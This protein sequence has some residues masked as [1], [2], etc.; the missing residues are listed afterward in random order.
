MQKVI[1][2]T[3]NKPTAIDLKL[4]LSQ[5]CKCV[6]KCRNANNN[7]AM[8]VFYERKFDAS[9][10][11]EMTIRLPQ[12]AKNVLIEVDVM[13]GAEIVSL[14]TKKVRLNSYAPCYAKDIKFIRFAQ[15]LC[16]MLPYLTASN[17]PFTIN[18][19]SIIVFQDIPNTMTPARIHNETGVIEVSKNKMMFNTVPVNM[20]ILL[21]E[22]SHF[23][24]NQDLNDEVEADLNSVKMYLGLGYPVY[25]ILKG[26]SMVFDHADVPMNRERYEYLQTFVDNFQKL[27]TKICR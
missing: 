25:E 11:E 17:A 3:N 26:F 16:D 23:Y 6:V 13:G 14:K 15:A 18:G 24:L 27:K 20:A 9:P 19:F 12:N 10:K 4:V 1:I 8:T 22:Y 5:D 2:N 21:H 7:K